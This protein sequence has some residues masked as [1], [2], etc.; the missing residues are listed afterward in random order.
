MAA[1]DALL[2]VLDADP[3]RSGFAN[4]C[5]CRARLANIVT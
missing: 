4:G 2:A 1:Y 3:P 5:A